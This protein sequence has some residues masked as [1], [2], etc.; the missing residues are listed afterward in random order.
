MK[1][2]LLAALA[3]LCLSAPGYGAKKPNSEKNAIKLTPKS[4]VK[5]TTVTLY[6]AKDADT[7]KTVYRCY[8]K[9]TAK[10]GQAY[11]VWL[12]ERNSSN[13]R[14]RIRTAY[15]QDSVSYLCGDKPTASCKNRAWNVDE[16]LAR[17]EDVDCGVE[18]RWL[19]SGKEWANEWSDDWDTTAWTE[20][21]ADDD[22]GLD[23]GNSTTPNTWTYYILVEGANG[24]KA[25]LNYI[26]KK[27][28][29]TGVAANPLVIKPK[30]KVQTVKLKDG[31]M[32]EFYY[33]Q[34][35]VK[36]GYCYRFG[37]NDGTAA[38]KL[39]F[40]ET[41]N[42]NLGTLGP[43]K[44][45][46]KSNNQGISF[47]PDG[48]QTILMRIRSSK[49]YKAPGKIRFFVE[50]QKA[51]KKHKSTALKLNKPVEFKPGYLNKPGS[52]YFDMVVDQE[53]FSL[54]AK[55][56]KNYV[57]ETSGARADVPIV[58]YLYDSK[59]NIL[60]TNRSKGSDSR[61]VRVVFT[62]S[63][64]ATYY[65]GVCEDHGIFDTF[66][67]KY[68]KVSI[69]ATTVSSTMKTV[70]LS[71]VPG[72]KGAKP[73]TVDAAGS[74]AIVL[75]KNNW[76]AKC[77]FGASADVTYA[78][79]TSFK[80]AKN[81][82]TNLLTAQIYNGK[83]STKT[84]VYTVT[85]APGAKFTY[86]VEKAG[87][88]YLLI[89]P[90]AGEGLDYK[91]IRVHSMGY[92]SNGKK[93]GALKVTLTG[94]KGMWKLSK[95]KNAT[96]YASGASVILP[97]GKKTL[98]FTA[99]KG[100]TTPKNVNATVLNGKTVEVGDIYYT[101]KWDPKDDT[102][103]K[104]TAWELKA[105]YTTQTKHTLWKTDKN[106]CYSFYS[107]KGFH[108]SFKIYGNDKGD[109]VL[110]IK[111]ASGK[112]LA[113]KVTSVTRLHLPKSKK[114]YYVIVSHKTTT[115]V[116]GAYKI[117][118]RFED[119]GVVKFT[120]P[121]YTAT[122]SATSVTLTAVRTAAKGACR[123]RYVITPGTAKKGENYI[124]STGYIGWK[125]G[126]KAKKKITI[127]LVPKTLPVK[128]KDLAFKVSLK[129]ASTATVSDGIKNAVKAAFPNYKKS[130]E[131]TVK[132][133][134][135]AKYKT[136]AAA[137][138]SVYKD[139]VKKEKEQDKSRLRTGTFYGLVR[140]SGT[141][142]T[143]G[144][145]EFAA[146]TLTVAAGNMA[147]ADKLTAKVQ[148][149]GATYVFKSPAGAATGWTGKNSDGT[150]KKTLVNVWKHNI[151]VPSEVEG[152]DPVVKV[153]IVT[154]ELTL[155][156]A[157]GNY[158]DWIKSGCKAELKM[159]VPDAEDAQADVAYSGQ[160]YR[161]NAKI[162]KYLDAAF[163]FDGYYT[164]SL[165]PGTVKGTN[166][167]AP[168]AGVPSGNGYLTLTVDNKGGVKVA[169]LLPDQSAVA[170]SV[171]ACGVV[172]RSTS[173][174]GYEMVVPVYQSTSNVCFA[175]ELRLFMQYDKSHLDGKNYKPVFD[176]IKSVVC[177]NSDIAATEDQVQGWRMACV[178]VGGWYDLLVNLQGYYNS[179]AK[180]FE[181]GAPKT[182]P[183]ELLPDGYQYAAT[184]SAV[185]VT[186]DGNKFAS[187][188]KELVAD[189]D[190]R[191]MYDFVASVNPCNVKIAFNR[192]TGVSSGTSSAW[193]VNEAKR[194][195]KQLAGFK[196]FGVLTIDRD[197]RTAVK[198]GLDDD[199][200]ISG[201]IVRP[202][203]INHRT[204]MF[205]VPFE[206][207]AD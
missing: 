42:L 161:R 72:T 63:K 196:H 66:T 164:V 157:D 87:M 154:N 79:A 47:L 200:L 14:I 126:D 152:E 136:A 4:S 56:G 97:V 143:N 85:F 23:W 39:T 188:K 204:W 36:G 158:S 15:G 31:F 92:F 82:E 116:G 118:G 124:S 17:F 69:T 43:Y 88:Y 150:L 78:F 170:A 110:S 127:R 34:V 104:A 81:T 155:A 194:V 137:Y 27:K 125:N 186:L 185:P 61:D 54:S 128:S 74:S 199:V 18:T 57:V 168:D 71:P 133:T 95:K 55:K 12:T 50:K 41:Y 32:G 117:K 21:I 35:K 172:A 86:K 105:K 130:A 16:P 101:D 9:L 38:N 7:G 206:V 111:D 121:T 134:N 173:K 37:T 73:R 156:V 205:S 93:C 100:Y 142:L 25:K 198:G 189:S 68:K 10:K 207:Y 201:A 179:L 59:G 22:W 113:K 167:G 26:A 52:G 76:T 49:G 177:W 176:S 146:V 119:L 6:K 162:Q 8:Y 5:T 1:R 33:V 163:L 80:D 174:T 53:L 29:P 75:G 94:A 106:D 195:Q 99:V 193:I 77:V 48:D 147:S 98:Y 122:D 114:P 70:N 203:L 19:M 84:L 2:I 40:D 183:A 202:V 192:A 182:F 89:R 131:A 13:T 62:P 138:A 108:Y 102:V 46:A 135:T 123:V 153:E 132:I 91:P 190:H 145:P 96:Q 171:T 83:V 181:A 148:V 103:K 112:Y 151:L 141:T 184:P 175:A 28:I 109:Q 64:A 45:W 149:A 166:R 24:A 120:K 140:E 58:A 187:A 51:I 160:L 144:A 165:V 90:A 191:S 197:T 169:G 180:A 115:N 65:I 3:A 159:H 60:K 178:P 44:T 107:K 67:P 30:N 11:T 139:K 20:M 129:D